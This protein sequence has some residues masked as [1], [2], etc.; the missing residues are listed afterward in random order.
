MITKQLFNKTFISLNLLLNVFIFKAQSWEPLTT[1]VTNSNSAPTSVD[2]MCV[3][4]GKLIVAGSF[5]NAGGT[6]ANN[7]AAWDGTDWSPLGNG[8]TNYQFIYG[9]FIFRDCSNANNSSL[10]KV[11]SLAVYNNEL[12]AAGDF[13][14]A[15]GVPVYSIA[16]WNGTNWSSVGGGLVHVNG[17]IYGYGG[18]KDMKVFNNELYVV[19]SFDSIGNIAAVNIAKWNGTYWSSVGGGI[20]NDL[21][22]GQFANF[23]RLKQVWALHPYNNNLYVGGVFD[24]VGINKPAKNIAVWDGNSWSNLGTG[25][26]RT[27]DLTNGYLGVTYITDFAGNIHVGNN[28]SGISK[29]NGTYWQSVGGGLQTSA[30]PG[31]VYTTLISNNEMITGGNYNKSGNID[32]TLSISKWNGTSWNYFG[33]LY[34]TISGFWPNMCVNSIA[35]FNNYIYVGGNFTGV[36]NQTGIT[37]V[38]R[39]ARISGLVGITENEKGSKEVYLYPNPA[40]NEIELSLNHSAAIE[41]IL[42][43]ELSGKE[44]LN[45]SIPKTQETKV[46]IRDLKPGAYFIEI[47]TNSGILTKPFIKISE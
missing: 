1:G 17:D 14:H 19:G 47:K 28:T 10:P 13:I 38:N 18:I 30:T 5:D 7:I 29:W 22:Y 21:S 8:L 41:K 44:V 36:C 42:V 16:K 11:R 31:T 3:Y 37:T 45:L 6:L 27:G 35:T 46:N 4:N 2:A 12:Y 26:P 34:G 32:N 23:A 9:S 39:I 24:T 33:P 20:K 15:D 40:S 43:R 25:I